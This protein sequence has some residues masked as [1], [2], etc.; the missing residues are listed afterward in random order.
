MAVFGTPGEDGQTPHGSIAEGAMMGEWHDAWPPFWLEVP[1]GDDTLLVRVAIDAPS[2]W[3]A[4]RARRDARVGAT[5]DAR[6]GLLAVE[7]SGIA[8]A[9]RVRVAIPALGVDT[10]ASHG[11]APGD[12]AVLEIRL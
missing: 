1:A 6:R 8:S 12:V 4:V 9:F 11:F 2:D 7:V 3:R 5:Y 10:G